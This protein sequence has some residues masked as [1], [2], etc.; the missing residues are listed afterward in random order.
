MINDKSMFYLGVRILL[1]ALVLVVLRLTGIT[2]MAIDWLKP[3]GIKA[4]RIFL[5][6]LWVL[7]N[8]ITIGIIVFISLFFIYVS[9]Q[10]DPNKK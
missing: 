5:I 6:S 8:Y 4:G 7:K 9:F 10:N 1:I 2:D 3:V